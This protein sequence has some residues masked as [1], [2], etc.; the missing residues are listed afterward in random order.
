M[1]VLLVVTA[2]GFVLVNDNLLSLVLLHY[3]S[4]YTCAC[5]FAA[6][7][8]RTVRNYKHLIKGYSISGFYI[9]LLYLDDIAL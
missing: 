8:E 5:N 9:E 4:G 6:N 3:L 2:L 7:F 1:T